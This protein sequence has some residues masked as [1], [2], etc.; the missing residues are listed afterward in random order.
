MIC[1][2]IDVSKGKSTVCIM[3]N[4]GNVLAK[5]FEV[6][7][8]QQALEKLAEE[9][10]SLKE[11]VRIVMEATGHYHLPVSMF[12]A[13]KGLWVCVENALTMKRFISY[14]LHGG[15][16]DPLDAQKIAWY[17]L[18]HWEK[19]RRYRL[20]QNTYAELKF[21]LGQY[22]H[23]MK[24]FVLAKQNLIC[25]MDHT[26]PGFKKAL[27]S[28]SNL[29]YRKVKYKD[30]AEKYRDIKRIKKMGKAGFI[31][32]YETWCR[33]EKYQFSQ[34][35]A[36]ELYHLAETGIITLP[37]KPAFTDTVVQMAAQEVTTTG[38]I[39]NTIVS[40]MQELAKTLPEYSV[41]RQMPGMGDVLCPCM[42]AAV[43]D[44]R[45]FYS[46]KALIAYA[47][48]DAPPFQSGQFIGS[49]RK[50]SKRGSK[51]IRRTGYEI[52]MSLKSHPPKTDTAVYDFIQK[53]EKEG[54]PKGVA[55]IAGLNK[56]LHIYYARVNALY[57][58]MEE[59]EEKIA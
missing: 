16:T 21:L 25:L 26:L 5:P 52:M 35:K 14:S 7:H 54:K 37:S 48:L 40:Q 36:C 44:V 1:V 46:A 3:E 6:L 8:T 9:I 45:R 31:R 42:I 23:A 12:L 34:E 39:L 53:K 59:Q 22:Y 28:R 32:S 57:Q 55:N 56:F 20:E 51:Y 18:V 24:M 41:V 30:F 15:K 58:A 50:I 2:G 33:K 43:G 4:L 49:K 10:T 29:D 38:E 13:E 47:G 19:L 27:D 11:P 17:G